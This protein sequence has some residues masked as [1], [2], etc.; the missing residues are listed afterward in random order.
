MAK[1]IE[2]EQSICIEPAGDVK[3][4]VIWLHGLGADGSD[5]VPI[6]D[7]LRFKSKDATRF[8][9][10]HAQ[11]M[12]VSINGGMEMRAWYDIIQTDLNKRVDAEG[13]LRS[14]E[15]IAHLIQVQIETDLKMSDIILAGFSQGGVIAL[16]AALQLNLP[17]AGVMALSTYLPLRETIDSAQKQNIFLAHGIDDG[18]IAYADALSAWDWLKIE[19][20]SVDWRN[21]PM[22]HSVCPEEIADISVWLDSVLTD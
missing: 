15:S 22:M 4:V 19:G 21:Y 10:P 3:K 12:P 14:V 7:D 8:I 13:I 20:H 5:F 1:L 16:Q 2:T 9:F 17:L 6:V 11:V 18:V